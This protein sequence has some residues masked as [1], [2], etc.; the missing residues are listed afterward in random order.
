MLKSLLSTSTHTKNAPVKL[1]GRY[2]MNFSSEISF[3]LLGTV[4]NGPCVCNRPGTGPEWIPNWT[5]QKG[6]PDLNQFRIGSR[7]APCKKKA[8]PVYSLVSTECKV[9]KM[10]II[11]FYFTFCLINHS[12][13]GKCE[14]K[15]QLG[16][17]YLFV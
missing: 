17:I 6:V 15:K 4:W 3:C 2:Q 10:T 5:C 14:T 7:M 16:I 13:F 1:R 11:R 9:I 8:D 12:L